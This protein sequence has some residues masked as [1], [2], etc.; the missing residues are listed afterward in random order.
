M[1]ITQKHDLPY[2]EII[3]TSIIYSFKNKNPSIG[4]VRYLLK[5]LNQNILISLFG[6]QRVLVL[7]FTKL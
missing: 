7:C 2:I 3:Y 6:I 5:S 1:L 4:N